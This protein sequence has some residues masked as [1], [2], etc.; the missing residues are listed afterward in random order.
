MKN[1]LDERLPVDKE[2]MQ[3]TLFKNLDINNFESDITIPSHVRPYIQSYSNLSDL[4]KSILHLIALTYFDLSFG[5]LHECVGSLRHFFPSKDHFPPNKLTSAIQS[6]HSKKI[7]SY[8]NGSV[9]SVFQ[10][11]RKRKFVL[12]Q[13]VLKNTFPTFEF[14]FNRCD[15]TSVYR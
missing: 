11:L 14:I 4:H 8:Y 12:F 10:F 5:A 6:L 15:R 2:K 3:T 13:G 7:L 9:A 1:S